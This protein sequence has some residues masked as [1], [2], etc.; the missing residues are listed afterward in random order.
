MGAVSFAVVIPLY[1]KADYIESCLASV[2]GQR[3]PPEQVIVVDDGSI[4]EGPDLVEKNGDPRIQL[5]RQCNSGPGTARN[6]GIE[7]AKENSWV[8]FLDADDLWHPDHLLI[9]YDAIC[10]H[11]NASVIGSGLL[12]STSPQS[13]VESLSPKIGQSRLI[14]YVAEAAIRLGKRSL[15]G[16]RLFSSSVSVRRELLRSIGGFNTVYPGEDTAT[17]LRLALAAPV[18]VTNQ[19]TVCYR[20]DTGGLMDKRKGWSKERVLSHPLRLELLE[21]LDAPDQRARWAILRC[22]LN[23]V[24]ANSLRGA[25]YDECPTE[26]RSL[27]EFFGPD[28]T[29]RLGAARYLLKVPPVV[30][31][32]FVRGFK[33]ARKL[34]RSLS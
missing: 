20:L 28:V 23:A 32:L 5:V 10:E 24:D 18:A 13:E 30:A 1:N 26:A 16:E 8:S 21:A 22:Y 7:E 3:Y 6:R 25:L 33:L 19:R 17:W 14:D 34:Q 9:H 29:A 15:G 4:D 31:V 2:L 27:S 11:S 12:P